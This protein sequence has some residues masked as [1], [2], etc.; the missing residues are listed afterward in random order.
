[1]I[2]ENNEVKK[3]NGD[4]SLSGPISWPSQVNEYKD[5][6]HSGK[7]FWL[8]GLESSSVEHV[9]ERLMEKRCI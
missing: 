6:K 8:E 9:L 1:M 3:I 2:N 7:R 4:S 5:G